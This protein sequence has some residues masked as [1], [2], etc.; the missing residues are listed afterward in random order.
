[1]IRANIGAGAFIEG[2]WDEALSWFEGARA[3]QLKAGN[4]VSAATAA[5][6]CGEIYVRQG[7]LDEAES[8]L[9]EAVRVMRASGFHDGAAYSEVQLGRVLV[10]RGEAGQADELLERVGAELA[11]F[12]RKSSVLEAALVQSL[13]KTRLGRAN[14]ALELIDRAAAAAGGA[15]GLLEPQAAEARA[16]ALAAL[17]RYDEA[18]AQLTGGLAAARKLGLRYEEGTLLRQRIA[19]LRAAGREPDQSEVVKSAEILGALGVRTTP[20]A[21]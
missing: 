7:R 11:R 5:S 8:I 20:S 9:R 19:V 14:E 4:P 15:S 6:N 13:A 18:E 10:D 1:M 3:A 16:L 2:R 21:P 12:G 17:G